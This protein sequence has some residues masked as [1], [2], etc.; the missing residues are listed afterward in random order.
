MSAVPCNNDC[1]YYTGV[2]LHGWAGMI[3]VR[4]PFSRCVKPPCVLIACYI[5]DKIFVVEASMP[6]STAND[7]PAIWSL[8]AKIV[9]TYQVCTREVCTCCVVWELLCVYNAGV[10]LCTCALEPKQHLNIGSMDVTVD[11]MDVENLTLRK[12]CRRLVTQTELTLLY[13]L[14]MVL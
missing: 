3:W 11:V 10:H 8:N 2:G 6:H 7:I 9:R 14:T 5:G 1:G 12:Y 13:I 4:G